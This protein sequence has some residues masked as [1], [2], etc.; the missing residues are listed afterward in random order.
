MNVAAALAPC[1]LSGVAAFKVYVN[2]KTFVEVLLGVQVPT[3][4]A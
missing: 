2:L 1:W 4:V 3:P